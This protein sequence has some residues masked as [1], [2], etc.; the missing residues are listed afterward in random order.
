MAEHKAPVTKIIPFSAVDGP[1]NRT[2]I[3][4]QG[5]NMDCRYCHNPETIHRCV[6]CGQCVAA[7]PVGALRRE[8]EGVA[9]EH[10]KC[11]ACDACLKACP[12]GSSPRVRMMDA[13]EL[14]DAVVPSLPFVEGVTLSGGECTLYADFIADFFGHMRRAGKTCFV[15]SNG[16]LPFAAMPRLVD[17]MDKAMLD[18]KAADPGEH[19]MLTGRPVDTVLENIE[20]LAAAGKL[21]EL[22]TVVVPGLLD[23]ARTVQA[24]SRLIARHKGIRYKLIRYRPLGVR[25]GLLNAPSPD[26]GTMDAMAALARGLGVADIVII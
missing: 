8:G 26:D 24:G 7:C 11:C 22:R 20:H 25:P 14:A 10:P 12:H 2:A 6:G 16:L 9:W 4:T 3:F 1:G 13:R 15:D 23:N 19:Q 17:A 18:L 5:C 21:F